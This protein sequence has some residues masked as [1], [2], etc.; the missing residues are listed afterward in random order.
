MCQK[1]M[2]K[3]QPNNS[4]LLIFN[5]NVSC[6]CMWRINGIFWARRTTANGHYT[7]S[8]DCDIMLLSKHMFFR[9]NKHF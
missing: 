1:P 3:A 6:V 8:E 5:T 7:T 9:E 2:G 4:D